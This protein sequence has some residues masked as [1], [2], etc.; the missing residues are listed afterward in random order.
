M[1]TYRSERSK[2]EKLRK[3]SEARGPLRGDLLVADV[4]GTPQSLLL[5]DGRVFR[6]QQAQRVLDSGRLEGGVGLEIR[7][8][9]LDLAL[10]RRLA[11]AAEE[12]PAEE[13]DNADTM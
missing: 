10:G 4:D 6:G 13:A 9:D 7:G 2:I 5:R 3:E 12:F 1:K 8:V 11:P